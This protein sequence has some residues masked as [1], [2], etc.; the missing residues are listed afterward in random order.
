MTDE[1][2]Q[3]WGMKK[4]MHRFRFLKF[5]CKCRPQSGGSADRE[6]R[7][8]DAQQEEVAALREEIA[9]QRTRHDEENTA[10]L[11][12]HEE[13]IAALRKEIAAQ[14]TRHEEEIAAL[15][16]RY[17]GG[18]QP[19]SPP[20]TPERV[21][22]QSVDLPHLFV[23]HSRRDPGALN[24][25]RLFAYALKHAVDRVFQKPF[26]EACYIGPHG[27]PQRVPQLTLWFDKE[28]MSTMGGAAWPEVL[29]AKQHEAVATICFLGNAYLG[30]SECVREL[31]FADTLL[32]ENQKP[33][34]PFFLESFV[35][36]QEDF[37]RKK[38]LWRCDSDLR[39]FEQWAKKK[40][41]A[42]KAAT[43]L[44]GVPAYFE[45]LSVFTCD[46]CRGKKDTACS[47]CTSWE[48]VTSGIY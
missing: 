17:E 36:S 14:R 26:C 42:R 8:S 6:E 45:D 48:T 13:E 27:G 29:A 33:L 15:R 18:G 34:I 1:Q 32:R 10:Q 22:S 37:D 47:T 4:E 25:A 39:K 35:N 46:K 41:Y 28:A 16:T 21:E 31:Q 2:L 3:R 20:S 24:A 30:S 11:T 12:P 40:Q 23:S 5:A 43:C 44:Q 7:S 38:T 9:A 19:H